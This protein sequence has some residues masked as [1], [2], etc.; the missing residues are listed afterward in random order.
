M[1]EET[2][3]IEDGIEYSVLS[4]VPNDITLYFKPKSSML[5]RKSGPAVLNKIDEKNE[6]WLDGIR[7]PEIE[8]DEEWL[9][10]QIVT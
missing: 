5:S 10:F 6:Y 2:N 8:S 1:I 4:N 3:I 9:L 7:Y